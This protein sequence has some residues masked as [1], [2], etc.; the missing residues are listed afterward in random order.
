MQTNNKL[1]GALEAIISGYENADLCDMNY[2]EW[3]HDPANVCVNVPLCKA[4]HEARAALAEPVKNCE[5][6]T[7]GQQDE[8][9]IAFC[10]RHFN[11]VGLCDK[12]CPCRDFNMIGGACSIVWAQMPYEE[13]GTR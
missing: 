1:R 7:V 10:N 3:C 8:R 2:G 6:G 12:A 13:G 11:A 5:V 9:F 4:I